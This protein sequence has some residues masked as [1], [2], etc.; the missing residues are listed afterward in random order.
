MVALISQ[1]IE[2]FF[3]S[4]LT[5]VGQSESHGQ[6]SR[7]SEFLLEAADRG[8][9]V[10]FLGNGASAS[11]SSTLAFKSLA[12][13]NVRALAL[14]DHNLLLG[15][16]RKGTFSTWMADSLR[17]LLT[18]KDALVLTSS[19]G[20]SP[21]IVNAAQIAA[22]MG[23]PTFSL[24]G[25]SEENTLKQATSDGLWVDSENYNVVESAHLLL[26][27]IAVRGIHLSRE[28]AKQ[29]H[30]DSWRELEGFDWESTKLSLTTYAE[31]IAN[32]DYEK[33]RIIFIGD[34]SSASLASHLAT[35]FSKSKLTAQALND[36]SFL[37]AS[38]NDFG[39]TEWLNVGFDRS[40]REGDEVV[41][42]SH[43]DLLPAEVEVLRK[44]REKK[45]SL[46]HHGTQKSN[47]QLSPGREF[48]YGAKHHANELVLPSIGLLAI[49]EAFLA[50][51]GP[52]ADGGD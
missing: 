5:A 36:H 45:A 2:K 33:N 20:E 12:E 4:F 11:I 28:A 41:V 19:S 26:G 16:S 43:A 21:N 3:D 7:L 13:Q 29:D 38:Q 30:L 15:M 39:S 9:T 50:L 52:Q 44:A 17:R 6:A 51:G 47:V 8:G 22:E 34:G 14:T 48:V 37:S 49:A 27:L 1:E 35:D 40:Y 31:E 18:P 42:V 46:S 24:T 25:F 23:V 32:L 10:F